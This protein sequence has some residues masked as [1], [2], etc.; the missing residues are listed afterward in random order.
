MVGNP[1]PLSRVELAERAA[2]IIAKRAKENQRAHGGTAPGKGKN[3]S[4]QLVKSDSID[5]R[6]EVAKLA[7]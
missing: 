5:T 2:P 4:D 7:G 1:D 6:H 3:T